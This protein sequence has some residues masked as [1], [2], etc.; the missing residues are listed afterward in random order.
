[1]LVPKLCDGHCYDRVL[2]LTHAFKED[3]FQLVDVNINTIRLNPNIIDK[4]RNIST[5]ELG[6][7]YANHCFVEKKEADGSIWVYDTTARLVIEK[8]LYYQMEEP[9]ITKINSKQA[10]EDYFEYIET[11]QA[12]IE[13]DKYAS[14]IVIPNIE[15]TITDQDPYREMLKREIE[16]FKEKIGYDALC[17]EVEED[18]KRVGIADDEDIKLLMKMFH[19]PAQK[20]DTRQ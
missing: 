11:E 4:S 10:T 16:I 2:L 15:A 14:I 13:R 19:A 6:K 5:G 7:N 3:Q 8:E 12:D 9:E 17:K 1:M 20:K 18:M